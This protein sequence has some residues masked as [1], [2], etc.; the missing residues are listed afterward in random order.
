MYKDGNKETLDNYL[1]IT[2]TSNVYKLYASVLENQIMSFLENSAFLGELHGAYRRGRRLEDHYFTLK[3]LCS[4]RKNSKKKTWLAFWDI[5]KAFDT[6]NKTR[7]VKTK[8]SV[9]Y[10]K[11]GSKEKFGA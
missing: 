7:D 3:G 9:L 5:I 4:L 6:V 8:C 11:L 2:L 1:S 10:V